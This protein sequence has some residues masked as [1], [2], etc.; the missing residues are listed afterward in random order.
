MEKTLRSVPFDSSRTL[1]FAPLVISKLVGI[2]DLCGAF[3][4]PEKLQNEQ[5]IIEGNLEK[6]ASSGE[7]MTDEKKLKQQKVLQHVSR[8]AIPAHKS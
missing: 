5:K 2:F 4:S 7:G 6:V 3:L 8:K 1:S